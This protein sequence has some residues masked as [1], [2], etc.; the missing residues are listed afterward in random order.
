MCRHTDNN[1]IKC[2]IIGF[3][4]PIME[5]KLV[6]IEVKNYGYCI[7]AT[8]GTC[9]ICNLYTNTY[10]NRFY[11]SFVIFVQVGRYIILNCRHIV[12]DLIE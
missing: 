7:V 4:A 11:F 8:G 6:I 1:K 5:K 3:C 12:R 9:F 10:I 2:R